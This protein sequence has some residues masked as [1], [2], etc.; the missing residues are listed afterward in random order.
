MIK[1]TKTY[2]QIQFG[3]KEKK[4]NHRQARRQAISSV[5]LA[6]SFLITNV[7]SGNSA[8]AS[9]RLYRTAALPWQLTRSL[10][11]IGGVCSLAPAANAACH[12]VKRNP[13]ER[14]Q[15]SHADRYLDEEVSKVCFPRCEMKGRGARGAKLA[16]DKSITMK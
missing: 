2:F 7:S 1:L 15:I 16:A 12:L 9:W 8:A 3:E 13:T 6:A 5:A 11:I 10:W 4:K 14:N